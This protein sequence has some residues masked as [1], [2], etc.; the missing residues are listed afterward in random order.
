[1][2]PSTT[3]H[4]PV[5]Q[6]AAAAYPGDF[7]GTSTVL[8]APIRLRFDATAERWTGPRF[9]LVAAPVRSVDGWQ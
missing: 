9:D 1:M 6:D 5:R 3:H 8:W 4:I 7:A 2:G